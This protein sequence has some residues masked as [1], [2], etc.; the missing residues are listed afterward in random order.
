[1]TVVFPDTTCSFQTK[2]DGWT[3]KEMALFWFLNLVISEI[4]YAPF[5]TVILDASLK[6][7]Q[8]FF[9]LI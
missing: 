8:V 5:L 7:I 6:I 3:K 1:M 4:M 2:M 9:Y